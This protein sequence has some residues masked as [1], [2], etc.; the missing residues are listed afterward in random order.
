MYRFKH[1]LASSALVCAVASSIMHARTAA[2][3][4][5]FDA[6]D[7]TSSK[8]RGARGEAGG[9]DTE[10]TATAF[11][12]EFPEEYGESDATARAIAGLWSPSKHAG[13]F[14]TTCRN[15]GRTTTAATST[16]PTPAPAIKDPN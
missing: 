14:T 5:V 2:A 12:L 15:V 10:E 3:S 4:D 11:Y 6:P 13:V 1:L 7:E 9:G 16:R 8:G